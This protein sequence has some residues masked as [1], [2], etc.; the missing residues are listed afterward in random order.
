MRRFAVAEHVAAEACLLAA[1]VLLLRCRDDLNR[2]TLAVSTDGRSEPEL[3]DAIGLFGRYLPVTLGRKELTSAELV[4]A[5]SAELAEGRDFQECLSFEHLAARG[6]PVGFDFGF[7]ES[8]LIEGAFPDGNGFR[9]LDQQF[10]LERFHAELIVTRSKRAVSVVVQAAPT[11]LMEEELA[12]WA[13][14]FERILRHIVERPRT[15]LSELELSCHPW[16]ESS[17]TPPQNDQSTFPEL[18]ARRAQIQPD[19]IAVVFGAEHVTYRELEARSQELA[20][21]LFER[22]VGCDVVVALLLDRSVDA[23]IGLLGVA[24]AGGVIVPLDSSDPPHRIQELMRTADISA[25]VTHA[26][27]RGL[28]PTGP[29]SIVAIEDITSIASR[30]RLSRPNLILSRS[31]AYVIFTS[32]TTGRPN[33][34][35]IEH[36]SLSNLIAALDERI[37]GVEEDGLRVGVNGSLAFDTS[38]KQWVQLHAGHTLVMIPEGVRR[39]A[40]MMLGFL[41]EQAIEVVDL[42]PSHLRLLLSAGLRENPPRALRLVLVGGEPIEPAM[43]ATLAASETPTYFNMYGPTE[44]TVDTTIG[45]ILDSPAA[46]SLGRAILNAAPRVLDSFHCRLPVDMRGELWIGGAGVARGY[47]GMPELTAMRFVPDPWSA[48][49]G[50]RLYRSGDLVRERTN[51]QLEFV[52]R[53][54]SFVKVRGYRVD[55]CDVERV[56][57][58]H[59]GVQEALVLPETGERGTRLRAFVVP[60]RR[61]ARSIRGRERHVLPNRLAVLGLNHNETEFLYRD[62]FER[63]AY[64]RH[65]VSL[66]RGDVVFDVGANIGLFSLCSH[67]AAEG[68]EVFAFEPNPE[69]FRVLVENA[70][71]YGVRG[72]FFSHALGERQGRCEFHSYPGFSILSGFHADVNEERRTV[73]AY[74]RNQA[75]SRGVLEKTF[76][77]ELVEDRLRSVSMVADVQ[78]LSTVVER[79]SVRRIDLLKINVEKAEEAVLQG[80]DLSTWDKIRSVAVEVHDIDGRLGRVST[81]LK[82]RGFTVAVERDWSLGDHAETNFYVYATRTAERPLSDVYTMRDPG[83]PFLRL[84]SLEQLVSAELPEHMRPASIAIVEKISLTA[85]GKLDSATMLAERPSCTQRAP[86]GTLERTI[87]DVWKAVLEVQDV[88]LDRSFF[89]VGGDSFRLVQVREALSQKLGRE[90]KV[91]DLFQNATI[92][93]LAQFLSKESVTLGVPTSRAEVARAEHHTAVLRASARKRGPGGAGA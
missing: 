10:E 24:R 64:F 23:I 16:K 66:R 63:R 2:S 1:W 71:L 18:F 67:F 51:G 42:T 53:L 28:L 87:Q 26:H 35:T 33:P 41:Q 72:R 25:V 58:S 9:A 65:G 73:L 11:F 93:A 5:L 29:W 59:P 69:A 90:L 7:R 46:A 75:S 84:E 55:P 47:L 83:E 79:H 44:C 40:E 91:M 86:R 89:D 39:D 15:T 68:V 19:A 4:Q 12:A 27:L 52:G 78:T 8:E 38:V 22:G 57:A 54:G 88:P 13:Q 80:I 62:I 34:C 81:L 14:A 37:Y 6:E 48:T 36:A 21:V 70:K 74:I 60:E 3:A 30:E 56:L 20:T 43:W 76:I 31:L 61:F 45:K 49:K 32:G 77:D 92:E 85:N 50:G 17:A 82:A